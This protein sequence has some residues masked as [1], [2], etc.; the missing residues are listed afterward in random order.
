MEEEGK[1]AATSLPAFAAVTEK[2][3]REEEKERE[4]RKRERRERA[5]EQDL[6]CTHEGTRGGLMSHH[7]FLEKGHNLTHCKAFTASH[8]KKF[9]SLSCFRSTLN[10]ENP[11]TGE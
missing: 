7:N 8:Q 11:N 1:E 10:E 5:R 4:R 2:N 9:R 6:L 3:E